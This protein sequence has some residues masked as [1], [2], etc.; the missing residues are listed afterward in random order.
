MLGAARIDT[1]GHF[2]HADKVVALSTPRPIGSSEILSAMSSLALADSSRSRRSLNKSRFLQ[3][4]FR[5][6]GSGP[7]VPRLLALGKARLRVELP[8]QQELTRSVR[9]AV[10]M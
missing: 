7:P 4:C 6:Q 5:G 2:V 1:R 3:Y 9:K 8:R 10:S